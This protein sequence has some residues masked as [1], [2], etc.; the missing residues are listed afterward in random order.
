LTVQ[1]AG[2]PASV[3]GTLVT[4]PSEPPAAEARSLETNAQCFILQL[5]NVLAATAGE[6][7]LLVPGEDGLPS[8]RLIEQCY[9]RRTL[10][11]QPWFTSAESARAH[12]LTASAGVTV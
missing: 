3:Q 9:A 10:V 4:P 11:E 8:L 6:E 7:P 12:E 5:R 2:A 1:L